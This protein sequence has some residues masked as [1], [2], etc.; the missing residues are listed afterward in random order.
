M[1]KSLP[2]PFSDFNVT[3][4]NGDATVVIDHWNSFGVRHKD[5]Y[6]RLYYVRHGRGEVEIENKT[7]V[8]RRGMT[9]LL[10]AGSPLLLHPSPGLDHIWVHFN[11]T[12][13]SGI[14]LFDLVRPG[15]FYL[16]YSP[17]IET[18]FSQMPLDREKMTLLEILQRESLVKLIL[19]PFLEKAE[20]RFDNSE[21]WLYDILEILNRRLGQPVTVAELARSIG[22]HPTYLSNAFS[23]KFGLGPKAYL[24]EKRIEKAQQLLWHSLLSLKE[25]G[26]LCGFGDTY[27]FH[28]CFKG[29]TG[30]TPGEY[31]RKR[32]PY[33]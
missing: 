33:E 16:E 25:I 14:P 1:L 13:P 5:G 31:R 19:I 2:F 7:I 32:E 10:P 21:E 17:P 3:V 23:R 24:M 11:G 9:I 27:Y 30:L 28:R 18:Y 8:L 12:A 29:A 4:L 20:S 22:C 6:S 26:R 15:R